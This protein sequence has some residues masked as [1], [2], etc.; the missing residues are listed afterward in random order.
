MNPTIL[1]IRGSPINRP[2]TDGYDAMS[3]SAVAKTANT[4]SPT[5]AAAF[6]LKPPG[7]EVM[8]AAR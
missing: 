3:N 5:I 8:R 2:D 4:L 1:T 7:S 6:S